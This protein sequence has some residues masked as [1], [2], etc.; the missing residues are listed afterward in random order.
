MGLISRMKPGRRSAGWPGRRVLGGAWLL[1]GC[2]VIA[3]A[4]VSL[5]MARGSS[6]RAGRLRG[7]DSEHAEPESC[8]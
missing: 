6:R 1:S 7:D 3:T 8:A 5:A 2:V 4:A